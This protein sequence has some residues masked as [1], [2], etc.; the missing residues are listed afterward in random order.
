MRVVYKVHGLRRGVVTYRVQGEKDRVKYVPEHVETG[1]RATLAS[2]SD[3]HT[4]GLAFK[5]FREKV[6][7]RITVADMTWF[8]FKGFYAEGV[9]LMT[10]E[11]EARLAEIEQQQA[12]LIEARKQLVNQAYAHGIKITELHAVENFENVV[13][14]NAKPEGGSK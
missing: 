5:K 7:A 10:P 12:A 11:D 9:R 14:P 13:F 4:R 1:E 3:F 6:Q 2:F 8:P